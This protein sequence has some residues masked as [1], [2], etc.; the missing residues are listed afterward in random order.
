M[1]YCALNI[2]LSGK[3][4]CIDGGFSCTNQL[5]AAGYS[6][7]VY[8][9][10]NPAS[11]GSALIIGADGR[12]ITFTNG[13]LLIKDISGSTIVPGPSAIKFLSSVT[14]AGAE[15]VVSFSNVNLLNSM[16]QMY[17]YSQLSVP[18]PVN[19]NAAI[20]LTTLP[21]YSS[22]YNF[23]YVKYSTKI[24][25][26][27]GALGMAGTFT[28]NNV[29]LTEMYLQGGDTDSD[30]GFVLLKIPDSKIISVN[31]TGREVN[32][33]R[34]DRKYHQPQAYVKLSLYGWM[35]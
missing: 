25:S 9:V 5:T 1:E 26:F 31:F 24:W 29:T 23:V 30:T 15:A 11:V 8:N 4:A 19:D 7:P 17:S 3:G 14:A 13:P 35:Y 21:G 2:G 16:T 32:P 6:Y 10:S 18:L 28:A 27:D 12:S 20:N 33:T 34:T 22:D